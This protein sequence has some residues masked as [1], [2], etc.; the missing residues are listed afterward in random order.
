MP[1]PR[2]LTD[3]FIE[4]K[5]R[6]VNSKLYMPPEIRAAPHESGD[7]VA[8]TTDVYRYVLNIIP[9]VKYFTT[10]HSSLYIAIQ[11]YLLKLLQEWIHS[12]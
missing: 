8:P 9:Q 5:R 3:K 11:F 1:N 7:V 12:V 2:L 6:L 4:E 10:S